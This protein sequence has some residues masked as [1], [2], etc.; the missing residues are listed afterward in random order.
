M[1]REKNTK[2]FKNHAKHSGPDVEQC[3]ERAKQLAEDA[4]R[5]IRSETANETKKPF[6]A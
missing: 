4:K 3:G 6:S 5:F 1:Q 2:Q